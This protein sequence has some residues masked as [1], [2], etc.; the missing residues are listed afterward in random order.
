MLQLI[1]I[2]SSHKGAIHK[3]L[4][5]FHIIDALSINHGLV[6]NFQFNGQERGKPHRIMHAL[7]YCSPCTHTQ[8]KAGLPR[9]NTHEASQDLGAANMISYLS[10][11]RTHDSLVVISTRAALLLLWFHHING[12]AHKK[13]TVSSWQSYK[14]WSY[15][16]VK[17]GL[18]PCRL[19]RIHLHLFC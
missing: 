15:P 19:G 13:C 16:E 7:D 1:Q 17:E 5:S 2:C 9:C 4:F 8:A 18:T 12:P 3:I 11:S 10:R 6:S 14:T